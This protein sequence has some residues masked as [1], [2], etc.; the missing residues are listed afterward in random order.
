MR[1]IHD[2]D[3]MTETARG[4]LIAGTVGIVGDGGAV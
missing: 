2:L 4:W 1:I 3:E